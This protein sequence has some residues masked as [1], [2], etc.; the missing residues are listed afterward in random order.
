[1]TQGKNQEASLIYGNGNFPDF[2]FESLLFVSLQ[3]CHDF[4]RLKLLN[5]Q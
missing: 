2:E 1:M 3:G 4:W 5:V